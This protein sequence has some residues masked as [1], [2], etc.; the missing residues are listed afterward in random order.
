MSHDF[1]GRV[2]VVTGATRG[3]GC[4]IA[5]ALA[6]Q[7]TR[8]AGW[9]RSSHELA[10]E[11]RREIADQ[12]GEAIF[13]RADVSRER[14]VTE[15]SRDVLDRFGRVDFLIN[16]AGIH[17][18]LKA[19]ELSLDDW[20][21]VLATNLTGQFL[22]SRAFI[23]AMMEQGFG[24]I[25]NISSCVAYMGTDHEVHYAASKSGTIALTK[26]LALEL[27]G[28]GIT[29]NAVAPGYIHSD[30]C[31]FRDEARRLSVERTIP[32]GRIGVP[33]DIAGPV[34]FLCSDAAEYITGQM[35][36]V[37]GGLVMP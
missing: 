8:V 31:R 29:V 5:R 4:G 12:G 27:A 1:T 19:W 23:P 6:A 14:D 18:H 15:A 10:T 20:N 13:M 28:F 16:N 11:V 25:V 32:L 34:S 17:Q 3:I 24:R 35:I 30:M 26:S 36:H 37:N 33:E 21:T 9:Y 22:V 2:A 7:G